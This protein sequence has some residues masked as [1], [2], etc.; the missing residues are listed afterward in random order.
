MSK[1]IYHVNIGKEGET[2]DKDFFEIV[3]TESFEEFAA[4]ATCSD[5]ESTGIAKV[6][7]SEDARG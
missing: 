3:E 2:D 4:Y 7:F 6:H 1:S 5:E